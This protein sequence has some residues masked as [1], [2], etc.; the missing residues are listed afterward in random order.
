MFSY[1][2][3][4]RYGGQS[5]AAAPGAL[6]DQ[7]RIRRDFPLWLLWQFGDVEGPQI[8]RQALPQTGEIPMRVGCTVFMVC[9]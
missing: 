9:A 5:A 2:V 4:S 1:S 8:R 6:A 3:L 7:L